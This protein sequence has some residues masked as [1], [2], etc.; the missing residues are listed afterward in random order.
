M[1]APMDNTQYP[2]TGAPAAYPTHEAPATQPMGAP[3]QA[4]APVHDPAHVGSKSSGPIDD[5]DIND[6]KDRFNKTFANVG[7]TVNSK[8]PV[9]AQ[10]YT[11]AF[12][13]CCSPIE[14][15]KFIMM[16]IFNSG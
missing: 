6:W 14:T 13:G 15:C 7:E 4:V 11:T 9:E 2:P 8:S 3:P 1:A 16:H 5:K 12:F 10:E